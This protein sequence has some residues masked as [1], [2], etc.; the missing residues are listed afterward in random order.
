MS[1]ICP[2]D[3]SEERRSSWGTFV[4]AIPRPVLAQGANNITLF[5]D[6]AGLVVLAPA[7]PN[8]KPA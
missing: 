4:M 3:A 1:P 7:R 2:H 5:R 6:W 8:N